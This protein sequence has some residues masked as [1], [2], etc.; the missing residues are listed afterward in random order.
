[1]MHVITSRDLG[2]EVDIFDAGQAS[3]GVIRDKNRG[4]T[5]I[6]DGGHSGSRGETVPLLRRFNN[7]IFG[8]VSGHTKL[9]GAIISHSDGDH[10]DLLTRVVHSTSRALKDQNADPEQIFTVYLGSP[11]LGFCEGRGKQCLDA[12]MA[13]GARIKPLSHVM[14]NEDVYREATIK[15]MVGIKPRP[16]FINVL[17]PEFSDPTRQLL[18]SIMAANS[19]YGGISKCLGT[20]ELPGSL[21]EATPVENFVEGEHTIFHEGTNNNGAMVKLTYKGK[22]VV[23]PGDVDGDHC[24]DRLLKSIPSASF[25]FLKADVSIAA[26]HGADKDRTNNVAWFLMSKPTYII[27]S[28]GALDGNYIHP[29]FNSLFTMAGI[30]RLKSLRV[31]PHT[32]QCGDPT[33]LVMMGCEELINHFCL[34]KDSVVTGEG[35]WLQMKTELPLYTTRTSGDIRIYLMQTGNYTIEES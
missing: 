17:I 25:S 33:G 31:M 18:L 3:S 9:A 30:L 16:Y 26:H 32:I 10:V 20:L 23:F 28:A 29:R 27:V 12:L 8:K 2:V 22:S 4:R 5:F 7:A 19:L 1:M 11:F 6:A 21:E 15:T 13:V 24:T 35:R 14:T 34:Q